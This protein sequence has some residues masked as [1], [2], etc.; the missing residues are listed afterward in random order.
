VGQ[1]LTD[2]PAPAHINGQQRFK[3][4]NVFLNTRHAPPRR[5]K[6]LGA[7]FIILVAENIVHLDESKTSIVNYAGL[8]LEG[9]INL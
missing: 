2:D 7:W 4:T 6:E 3:K 5:V 8:P 1:Q 9:S